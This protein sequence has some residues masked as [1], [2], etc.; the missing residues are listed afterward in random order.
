MCVCVCGFDLCK[1][2][3]ERA[4]STWESER[5]RERER[6][7]REREEREMEGDRE[8]REKKERDYTYIILRTSPRQTCQ[9]LKLRKLVGLNQFIQQHCHLCCIGIQE[10]NKIAESSYT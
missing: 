5:E 6:R 7:E 9:K 10:A 2:H 8:E 1:S 4:S 3:G